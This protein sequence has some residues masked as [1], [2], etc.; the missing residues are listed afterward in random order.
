M[1]LKLSS[2]SSVVSVSSCSS[3]ASFSSSLDAGMAVVVAFSSCSSTYSY[4]CEGF[5]S[6]VSSVKSLLSEASVELSSVLVVL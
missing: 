1:V 5:D 3:V 2:G 6:V 4:S